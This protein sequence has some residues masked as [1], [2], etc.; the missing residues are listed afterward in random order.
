SIDSEADQSR[1]IRL[2]DRIDDPRSTRVLAELAV[3]AGSPSVQMAAIDVLKGRPRRDYAGRLVEWI[4]GEIEYA[5]QPGGRPGPSGA[6]ILDTP[7]VRWILTYDTP[8]VFLPAS[9]FRG[10]VGYDANGLPVI[11]QG[12]ELDQLRND[13]NPFSVA[14][15]VREIEARTAALIAAA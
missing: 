7:R 8:P 11:A 10:Y 9:S 14:M 15:K 5:G 13:L 3:G 4:R 1:I 12:R 2:L 6:L